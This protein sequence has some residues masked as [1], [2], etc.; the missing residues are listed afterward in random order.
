TINGT[1]ITDN[2]VI[3][4][5]FSSVIEN[6]TLTIGTHGAL[7]ADR[8]HIDGETVTDNGTLEVIS[9]GTLTLDQST[10]ISGTGTITV[11]GEQISGGFFEQ[12]TLTF[13][14]A[15]VNGTAIT[16]SGLIDLIGTD[17]IENGTLTITNFAFAALDVS[18]TD[19]IV[20]ETVISSN[21]TEVKSGGTL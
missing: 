9:A 14:T 3:D 2:G 5:S 19:Q 1:A 16:D 17:T 21:T 18:G 7:D 8:A 4:L 11:D 10:S 13:N 15:I 12:T 20:S 6:G